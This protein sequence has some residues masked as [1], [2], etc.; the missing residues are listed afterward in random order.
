MSDKL[1]FLQKNYTNKFKILHFT[2][3]PISAMDNTE[4]IQNT[5]TMSTGLTLIIAFRQR[6]YICII[7]I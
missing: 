5:K 3:I 2:S 1:C 4:F 6:K 7:C